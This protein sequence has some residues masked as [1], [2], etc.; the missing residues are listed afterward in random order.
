MC[1]ISNNYN[2]KDGPIIQVLVFP[3]TKDSISGALVPTIDP[4]ISSEHLFTKRY[5]ALVDT[6]ATVTCISDTVIRERL[7]SSP[8]SG[9][10]YL[11]GVK[12]T[13]EPASV[14]SVPVYS[15][16]IVFLLD[17]PPHAQFQNVQAPM[18]AS[19]GNAQSLAVDVIIGLDI[20]SRGSLFIDSNH[21]SL[22]FPKP[23]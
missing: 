8:I 13:D 4:A 6:G 18:V 9:M 22:Q 17:G 11:R 16:A 3:L 15:V 14:V 1:S 19:V 12:G 20:I 2:L 23:D 10:T 21:F 7:P 5:N